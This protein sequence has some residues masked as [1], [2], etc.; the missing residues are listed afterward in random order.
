MIIPDLRLK[1]KQLSLFLCEVLMKVSK[2]FVLRNIAQEHIL[3]PTGKAAMEV[4]GLIALSESGAL[5]FERLQ[6]DA[7][8]EQLLALLLAEYDVSEDEAGADLNAF[9]NQMRQLNMLVE[10]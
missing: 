6:S 1:V 5:L 4:K 7:T 8:Y 2:Q 3:I 9:L 10:E